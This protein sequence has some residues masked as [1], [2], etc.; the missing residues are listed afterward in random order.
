MP[1]SPDT[2]LRLV[3]GLL[4]PAPE[5]PRV[6]AVDDWALRKGRTYETIVVDLERRRAIDLLP[7]RTSTTVADWLRQ[8]PGIEVVA[9]D[10]STEYARAASIGAPKA[11][12]VA[13][14][15]HFPARGMITKSCQDP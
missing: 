6:V 14:R 10:R 11:V 12:Q 9:R 13:D 3:C 8:R 4:L 2:A 1:A 15:W 7:D 5:P